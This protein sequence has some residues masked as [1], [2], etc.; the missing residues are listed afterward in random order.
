MN[1]YEDILKYNLTIYAEM[2]KR[3]EPFIEFLMSIVETRLGYVDIGLE[4]DIEVS[5]IDYRQLENNIEIRINITLSPS[6]PEIEYEDIS[7]Y[8]FKFYQVKLLQC[9]T[10]KEL[11]DY[12][13]NVVNETLDR[14]FEIQESI[15]KK[16]ESLYKQKRDLLKI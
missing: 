6:Y 3:M 15:C 8:Q 14:Y 1:K 16:K 13:E 7:N 5:K 10:E 9:E 12:I 11:T 2:Q 4:Q